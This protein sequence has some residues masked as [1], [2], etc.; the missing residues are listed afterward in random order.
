MK[1]VCREEAGTAA[2]VLF[3]QE[4]VCQH[5]TFTEIPTYFLLHTNAQIYEKLG[6][7]TL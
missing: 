6:S 4:N 2:R 7:K 3:D 5:R 1:E